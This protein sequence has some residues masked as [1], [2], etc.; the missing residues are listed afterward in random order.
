MVASG[1]ASRPGITLVGVASS[2]AA[3][4][5]YAMLGLGQWYAGRVSAFDLGIFAQIAAS[6]SEGGPPYSRIRGLPMLAEH[7]S[8][9]LA[10]LGPAWAVWPSPVMLIVAQALLLAVASG[11][12]VS[13]LA[14][15]LGRRQLTALVVVSI[16]S[17]ATVSAVEFDFHEV[18]FAPLFLALLIIG[19]RRDL[20][21]LCLAGA[22]GLVLT[23]EDL[24]AT[25]IA[26]A[27]LWWWVRRTAKPAVI[28][29]TI[30]VLG[31]IVGFGTIAYGS[32]QL[33]IGLVYLDRL[34]AAPSWMTAF[35]SMPGKLVPSLAF[36]IGCLVVG[37]RDRVAV[38]AI[39]TLAWRAVAGTPAY[40]ELGW[41]YDLVL[42]PIMIVCAAAALRRLPELDRPQRSIVVLAAGLSL[43]LGCQM[44][45]SATV[46]SL[47]RPSPT[48]AAVAALA[49]QLPAG[50][51]VAAQDS[52]APYLVQDFDVSVL[53]IRSNQAVQYVLLT[54]SE[55][56]GGSSVRS[57]WC[58]RQDFIRSAANRRLGLWHRG[59]L[60]LIR[61]PKLQ[62]PVLADCS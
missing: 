54:S 21:P 53:D 15:G 35:A 32:H 57:P 37:I 23:K 22:I 31:L 51:R 42:W 18:A 11:L 6:W 45:S 2:V 26:A 52:L 44:A 55:A 14:P 30:G 59:D 7:F 25:V 49:E 33:G 39:P 4:L 12:L 13:E 5:G 38:L 9:M 56:G 47:V 19:I 48:I 58:A 29:A 41:H 46:V 43:A 16:T 24:G 40:S 27:L 10:V 60:Y 36:V 17:Y 50:A 3:F 62:V 61:Q 8:P 20:L 34:G 28:L 1:L